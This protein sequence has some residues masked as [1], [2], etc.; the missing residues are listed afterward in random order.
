MNQNTPLNQITPVYQLLLAS[1]LLPAAIPN[2]GKY[3]GESDNAGVLA[4]ASGPALACK[5]AL[6]SIHLQ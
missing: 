1:Q 4:I 6:A 5:P 2:D 3:K